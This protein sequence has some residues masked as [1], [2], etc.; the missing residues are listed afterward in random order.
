[1]QAARASGAVPAW[2]HPRS[3]G[4]TEA[5]TPLAL[6]DVE[7]RGACDVEGDVGDMG[8]SV[9]LGG[10]EWERVDAEPYD[11]V[12]YVTVGCGGSDPD[13]DV[14]RQA[15]WPAS[16]GSA[17]AV[18]RAGAVRPPGMSPLCPGNPGRT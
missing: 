6:M 1:M 16:A 8:V 13:G 15:W 7:R 3:L 2:I 9:L 5:M 14:T 11:S 10:V 12:G 18:A 17:A 4:L